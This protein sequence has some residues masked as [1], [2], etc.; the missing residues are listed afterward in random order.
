M[1]Q[2]PTLLQTSLLPSE[3][4]QDGSGS[5]PAST[6]SSPRSASGKR[7]TPSN[8]SLDLS[9]IPPLS[10]P[11]PPSNTLLITRLEDPHIFHPAS[12]ATIRQHIN[13]IA[14]LNSF[15]PLKSL[16]RI[17][18]SFYDTQSAIRVRQEFDGTAILGNTVAKCYFGEATPIGDEKRYL[19]KPDAGKLFFISPPPSPPIGWESKNED[20]PNKEVHAHD[21]AEKLAQLTSRMDDGNVAMMNG[22]TSKLPQLLTGEELRKLKATTHARSPTSASALS[23]IDEAT[24]TSSPVTK[25][26]P[27]LRSRSSTLIYD[28]KLHGDSPGLPAVM[29][30]TEDEEPDSDMDLE[31]EPKRIIAHTSRPPVELMEE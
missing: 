8:L 7:R 30:E 26:S 4:Q 28:P 5:P 20:P 2:S 10:T 14:R 11:A 19:D 1:T 16:S 23:G 12:L 17:I 27:R 25:S 18:C 31:Q 3:H 15:S 13:E 22:D 9:T 29:L 21:L 24:S 6:S